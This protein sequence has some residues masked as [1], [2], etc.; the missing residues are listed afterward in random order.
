MPTVTR[1]RPRP[2][3]IRSAASRE[4][5]PGFVLAVEREALRRGLRFIHDMNEN[6]A[7]G[8]FA[9]PLSQDEDGRASSARCYLTPA[10]RRRSN[11]A[12]L[13]EA[14]VRNIHFDG[15]RACGATVERASETL[16]VSAH[17]MILCVGAIHSPAL[18]LRAGIGPAGDL[19]CLGITPR[20]NR[21]GVGRNLQNHPYLHFGLT[22][23]PRSRLQQHLRRFAV[24][25]MRLSSGHEGCPGGDLLLFMIGRVS[26]RSYGT[27]LAMF[28]AALYSPWSRGQVRLRS[29]QA[30]VPPQIEFRMFE[31][32]RVIRRA[33][34]RRR[35][36]PKACCSPTASPPLTTTPFCYR[37]SCRC[38]SSTA[39]A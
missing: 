25:G 29:A 2:A 22:L 11:L 32:I 38:T 28:G 18:L 23:P 16:Q 15:T 1:R 31:K 13:P 27:D 33:Y 3:R 39:R 10:V 6:P 34:S 35:G 20:A 9:M 4:E 37:Q 30:K 36:L 5:W 19:E 17:E 12:I 8:F 26:P 21:A 24:A 14:T 7:D